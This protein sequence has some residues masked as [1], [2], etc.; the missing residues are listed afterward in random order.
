MKK[1]YF[2]AL[3]ALIGIAFS[4]CENMNRKQE[5]FFVKDL[6][7]KWCKNG[8]HDY[9]RFS[10]DKATRDGYLWGWEWNED[11][12]TY[13][14]YLTPQGNSWF[15]YT[16]EGDQLLEIE[17]TE[18]GWVDIPKVYVIDELTSTKLVYHPKDYPKDKR[19]YTKQPN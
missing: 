3:M 19:Y 14:D 10:A 6:Q 16:I 15:M 12:G 4:S 5:E 8:V 2:L 7:G 13:E 11:E 18:Y 17:K 1:F 9:R